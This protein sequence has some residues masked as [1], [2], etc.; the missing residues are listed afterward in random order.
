MATEQVR[1]IDRASPRRALRSIDL[2]AR[3]LL[4]GALLIGAFLSSCDLGPG[5]VV[6]DAAR[7]RHRDECL[8]ELGCEQVRVTKVEDVDL[9][10]MIDSSGSMIEEHANLIRQI[11]QLLAALLSGDLD[12]DGT[13][14]VHPVRSLHVGIVTSDMGG[15]PYDTIPTCRR[16]LGDDGI[17]RAT[18]RSRA[19]PC[20]ADYPSGLFAF[21][22]E[23]DDPALF[24]AT[25]A[26]VA[27][28]GTGGCGF[29]QQLESPL[30]A[31]TPLHATAWTRHGYVPPRFV[32][33]DGVVDGVPGNGD[34]PGNVGFLRPHS[35][36][37]VVMLTDEDDCSVLDYGLYHTSDPRFASVPLNVRCFRFGAPEMHVV[38]PV[39]RYVSGFLGLRADPSLLVFSA[40]VGIPPAAEAAAAAG[41]YAAVLS[42]PSMTP[43]IDATGNNLRPACVTA[44][45]TAY[46]PVRIVETAAGLASAGVGVSLSSICTSTFESAIDGL[47][48]EIAG[49]LRGIC[50]GRELEAAPD[51]RVDCEVYELLPAVGSPGAITRCAQLAEQGRTFDRLVAGERELCRV[52]QVDRATAIANAAP[53]WYYDDFDPTLA[54][55]CGPGARRIAFTTLSPQ[56]LGSEVRIECD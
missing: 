24:E 34:A 45:G 36:L 53:G 22:A 14:E 12:A 32:S 30:K 5:I 16:G 47:L 35:A 29:E 19:P 43:T 7:E 49:A 15:G 31:L 20:M 11:P 46:P 6:P 13:P 41:D 4:T 51:G 39:D 23:T 48:D 8:R 27:G 40:I 21:A 56:V 10:L 17:L 50:L 25:L 33:A 28:V 18:S 3:V 37:A 26:C 52:A 1:E 44:D 2:S 38:H 42:H 9:L 54:Q 55:T